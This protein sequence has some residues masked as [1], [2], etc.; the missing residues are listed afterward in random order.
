MGSLIA[1]VDKRG[2]DATRSAVSMLQPLE[3]SKNGKFTIASPDRVRHIRNLTQM[4]IRPINSS[5]IIG[6]A[7][8]GKQCT[9]LDQPLKIRRAAV[10]FE[11]STYARAQSLGEWVKH[12]SAKSA[13]N[14]IKKTDGD[15]VFTI[16]RDNEITAGRDA[17]GGRPLYFGE[18]AYLFGLASERKS[19]WRIGIRETRD[20]PP[21]HVAVFNYRG[22]EFKRIKS[23]RAATVARQDMQNAAFRLGKLLEKST[24]DRLQGLKKATIAF[25]GGLD[26]S[27][28]AYLAKRS[29]ADIHLVHVTV[30]GQTETSDALEAADTLR[31][32]IAVSEYTESDVE[33]AASEVIRLIEEPDP[34]KVSIG[35]PMLWAAQST[36]RLN[37]R[38]MLAGQGADEMFGGYEKYVISYLRDG[39]KS[40]QKQMHQ[41]ITAL[42]KT[43]LDRDS[44]I[45]D[46]IGIDLRLPFASF[47]T[48]GFALGLPLEMK[49]ERSRKTLRKLILRRVA[50]NLG[51]PSRITQK[52]KKAVQY[53]T[54]VARTLEKSARRQGT[55]LQEYVLTIFRKQFPEVTSDG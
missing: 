44:K 25:S 13:E 33:N 3:L 5:V 21:G 17:F 54:G 12:A 36:A 50:Q 1:I 10:A 37:I 45:C 6:Y 22:I 4:E 42:H 46:S 20:F 15:Y 47:G 40:A 41:D 11:G 8:F 53:G 23:L 29:K 9:N 27:V 55:T 38:V 16:C 18:N 19:L 14:L 28:I 48:A 49:M 34:V 26:S 31:T 24:R 52:R 30:K 7:A 32:P 2:S 51:L 43:N 35:I 39:A